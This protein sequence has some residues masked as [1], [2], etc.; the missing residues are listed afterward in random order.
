M[1]YTFSLGGGDEPGSMDCVRVYD[2]RS[3]IN[4]M[5]SDDY[6]PRRRSRLE[7]KSQQLARLLCSVFKSVGVSKFYRIP[8]LRVSLSEGYSAK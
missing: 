2:L 7:V 1:R 5:Q 6:T 4:N 3:E 8:L